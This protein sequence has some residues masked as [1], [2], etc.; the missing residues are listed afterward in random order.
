MKPDEKLV[1]AGIHEEFVPAGPESHVGRVM[2][3]HQIMRPLIE[4]GALFHA[5]P[6]G[7]PSPACPR[8]KRHLLVERIG[9]GKDARN[10]QDKDCD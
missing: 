10:R 7:F 9:F 5:R 8:N 6:L 3:G 2:P 4:I 1:R